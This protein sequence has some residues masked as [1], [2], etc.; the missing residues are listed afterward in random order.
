M[1]TLFSLGRETTA[2]ALSWT[3]YLL[4]RHPDV[5]EKLPSRPYTRIQAIFHRPGF[6][7]RADRGHHVG[8]WEI[9]KGSLITVSGRAPD[10]TRDFFPNLN[11]SSR[12]GSLRDGKTA[13]R[14][15]PTSHL[16][17]TPRVHW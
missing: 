14:A 16:V 12:R 17:A 9:P 7:Q 8:E 10:R 13:F 6:R 5:E 3:W 15:M 2:H 11:S 4:P 1:M